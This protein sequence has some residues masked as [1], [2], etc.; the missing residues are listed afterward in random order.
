MKEIIA[1][2]PTRVHEPQNAF[3]RL[4]HR[5]A[6][7]KPICNCGNAYYS[8]CGK[9]WSQELGNHTTWACQYGCLTNCLNAVG[10]IAKCVEEEFL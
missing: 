10:Y 7:D 1:P 9:S 6:E 3:Q 5:Y 2:I 4:L 8:P